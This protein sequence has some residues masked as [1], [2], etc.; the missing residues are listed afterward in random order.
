[1][2]GVSTRFLHTV[3]SEF[4]SAFDL[5]KEFQTLDDHTEPFGIMEKNI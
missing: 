5:K 1:M 4:V 3:A 2:T